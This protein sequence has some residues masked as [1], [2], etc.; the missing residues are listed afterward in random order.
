MTA[1]PTSKDAVVGAIRALAARVPRSRDEMK[2]LEAESVALALH[3]QKHTSLFDV[4][5]AVWHFLSDADIRFK[6]SRYAEAQLAGFDDVLTAWLRGAPSNN[7]LERT[8]E[9]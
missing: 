5:E 2:A 1:L 8:R 3:I 7:S 6:D 9:G 4:P